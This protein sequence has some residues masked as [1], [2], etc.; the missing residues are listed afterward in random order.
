MAMVELIG[1]AWEC[2]GD[3]VPVKLRG[4]ARNQPHHGQLSRP[5]SPGYAAYFFFTPTLL[6]RL[7]ASGG[8]PLFSAIS[9]SCSMM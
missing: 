2:E 6:M 7:I 4:R 9:R 3:A 5:N 8:R 1:G